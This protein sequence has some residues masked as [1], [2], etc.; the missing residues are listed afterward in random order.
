MNNI[1]RIT[2]TEKR[3]YQK[4]LEEIVAG[5]AEGDIKDKDLQATT[6][7]FPQVIRLVLADIKERDHRLN[8]QK[9]SRRIIEYGF[10][11][12]EHEYSGTVNEIGDL[13]KKLRYAKMERIR[14]YT[15]DTNVCIDGTNKMARKSVKLRKRMFS[16]ISTMATTLGLEMSSLIRLCV[17]HSLITSSK[18]PKEIIDVS[19]IEIE[20][21]IYD[22]EETKSILE[23]FEQSEQ[24]W[25]NKTLK[26]ERKK[27]EIVRRLKYVEVELENE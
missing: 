15:M 23:S 17:Y 24:N 18:L 22:L 1:F 3:N 20:T 27:E 8:W 7:N 11:I 10:S 12:I 2:M 13:K 6:V 14:N 19:E 26:I 4:N 21:F 9:F 16:A 25:D 5:E